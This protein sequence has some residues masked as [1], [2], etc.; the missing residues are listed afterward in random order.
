[1]TTSTRSPIGALPLIDRAHGCYLYDTHGRDYLD[2]SSGVL[3][4]NIGHAHPAVIAAMRAQLDRVAFVHRTQFDNRP[5]QDLTT[6]LLQVA[7]TNTTAVEFSNSG[8][9]ANETALRLVYAYHHRRNA[10]ERTVIL[11]EEPSYHGMTAGALAI[12]GMPGKRDPSTGPLL[13]HPDRIL[14]QP[15][16]GTLRAQRSDWAEAIESVGASRI[17]AIFVEPLGGASSGA[18]PIGADTLQWLRRETEDEGILLVAD[19]VMSGFGRT[20]HWWATEHSAIAP[21]ITTS[22]KG[23]TGGY[24]S[25]AVTFV[26]DRVQDG[27]GEPVGPVV[28]GHTM[29]AN[30]LAC[31]AAG[32]VLDVLTDENLPAA[33]RA[34]GDDLAAALTRITHRHDDLVSGHT[35]RG[36]MRGLHLLHDAPAGTNRQIVSAARAHGLILCA[37]G[38]SP[39]TQAILIAPPLTVDRADIDMLETRL[40]ATL[41]AVPRHAS[42]ANRPS[43]SGDRRRRDL[44]TTP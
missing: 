10:P 14:V 37:A 44:T 15:R 5:A 19:E 13:S 26:N 32:A 40:E 25:L 29:S 43:R 28:L 1:M 42:L 38:I 20:G 27:I 12:T 4:V 16:N 6:R 8:S 23:I 36:L 31:A 39:H 9:E 7:P 35:G 33:A 17:A 30:P 11:S 18:A 3:N 21:D 34:R 24:T 22:G 41:Q 2:G